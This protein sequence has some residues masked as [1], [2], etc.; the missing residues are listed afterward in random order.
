MSNK[1]ENRRVIV[2][3]F[4]IC[5]NKLRVNWKAMRIQ[6]KLRKPKLKNT[7]N[8]INIYRILKKFMTTDNAYSKKKDFH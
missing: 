8:R 3:V 6:S 2:L 4:I 1:L 5:L 7:G